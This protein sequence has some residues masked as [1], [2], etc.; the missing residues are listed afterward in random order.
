LGRSRPWALLVVLVIACLLMGG[1]SRAD[2]G[3]LA[4]LRPLAAI[5]LVIGLYGLTR[6]RVA[7]FR[8][9]LLWGLALTALIG[10]QLVPLPPAL[11]TALPGRDLLLDGLVVTGT[12]PGWQP[13]SMV[14]WRTWNSL[15]AL[16]VPA[17]ALFLA[18]RAT[19]DDRRALVGVLL[20]CGVATTLLGLF[21]AIATEADVLWLYRITNDG[22]PVGF[23]ANRNH[24][25]VFLSILPLLLAVW[26]SRPRQAPVRGSR[27]NAVPREWVA[28]GA[29]LVLL[30]LVLATGSRAGLFL[31]ALSMAMAFGLYGVARGDLDRRMLVRGFAVA[32]LI[33]GAAVAMA[34]ASTRSTAIARLMNDSFADDLRSH[35]WPRSLDLVSHYFPVGTG[36]GSFAEVFQV[37]EPTATLS[38][39]YINRVH[40]DWLEPL[41]E[42]GLPAAALL[43]VAVLAWLTVTIRLFGR[44]RDRK[45]RAIMGLAGSGIILLFALGS[46]AD[47]PLRVPLLM[48]VVV[49]AAVWMRD[50]LR[51]ADVADTIIAADVSLDASGGRS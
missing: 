19:V 25:A 44:L 20:L 3:S 23:F 18:I 13:I 2:I 41:L 46:I 6:D 15:F 8:F 14:P 31:L 34:V 16:I 7:D 22:F 38:T 42:G 11:W 27:V 28:T 49:I 21:Q 48:V 24:Q 9:L 51:Q 17:A 32:V 43:L 36:F 39:S 12:P 50:G 5:L 33:G 47:Y 29:V 26:A 40:N 4:L 37:G 30:P 10:L 35:V 45:E 1:G